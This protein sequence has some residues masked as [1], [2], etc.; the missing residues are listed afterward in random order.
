V[1][2]DDF[3]SFIGGGGAPNI[4]Q[5]TDKCTA[6]Y[7]HQLV[8]YVRRFQVFSSVSVP[9]NIIKPKKIPCFPVMLCIFETLYR[10]HET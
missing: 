6:T 5:L 7:I 2:R 9:R 3:L 10:S 4:R 1:H 8:V